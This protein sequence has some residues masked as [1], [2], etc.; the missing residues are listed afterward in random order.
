MKLLNEILNEMTDFAMKFFKKNNDLFLNTF[1]KEI[2]KHI[3]TYKQNI[4]K[5]EINPICP[6]VFLSDHA[7]GR[8][9]PPFDTKFGTAILCNVTTKMVEKNFQICSYRDYGTTNY[10]NFLKKL[11]EKWLFFSKIRWQ[12]EKK[13]SR[14]FFSF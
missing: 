12:L 13:C 7:P 2:H 8:A 14:S 9:T 10:V 4:G 1:G 3:H 11:C 5:E 6:R